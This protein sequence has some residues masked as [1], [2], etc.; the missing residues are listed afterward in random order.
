MQLL[1]REFLAEL[2][3]KYD[4]SPE[5]EE[6]FVARFSSKESDSE[7]ARTICISVS[8]LSTRMSGVYGKFSIGGKGPGKLRKLHDFLLNEYQKSNPSGSLGFR[9]K[10]SSKTQLIT[11]N[12]GLQALSSKES[13]NNQ[14]VINSVQLLK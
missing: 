8:A 12:S 3:Q 10:V 13:A 1:P 14:C 2:A 6:A 11:Q 7:V 5:Q 4:L 9:N